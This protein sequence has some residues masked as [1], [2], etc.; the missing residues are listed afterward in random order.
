MAIQKVYVVH[1]SSSHRFVSRYTHSL[2]ILISA[3]SPSRFHWIRFFPPTILA[4]REAHLRRCSGHFTGVCLIRLPILRPW[5]PV[6]LLGDVFLPE[7]INKHRSGEFWASHICFPF[8]CLIE[9]ITVIFILQGNCTDAFLDESARVVEVL[10][11]GLLHSFVSKN[12]LQ[13]EV[14]PFFPA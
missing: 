9:L 5:L 1:F 7:V 12:A 11:H 14:P 2:F 6:S 3:S 8:F 4:W 10:L 13:G